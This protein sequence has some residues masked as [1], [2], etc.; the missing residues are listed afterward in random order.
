MFARPQVDLEL[1]LIEAPSWATPGATVYAFL[2]ALDVLVGEP[3]FGLQ[4]PIRVPGARPAF[5]A[6]AFFHGNLH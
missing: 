3:G 5:D 2:P 1:Q 4:D 6:F